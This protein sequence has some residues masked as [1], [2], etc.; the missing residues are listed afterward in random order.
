MEITHANGKLREILKSI[1]ALRW[2]RSSVIQTIDL[3][4]QKHATIRKLKAKSKTIGGAHA[5]HRVIVHS[6]YV[7]RYMR[8][9]HGSTRQDISTGFHTACRR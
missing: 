4:L 7:C 6:T 9:W 1:L 2:E 3:P 5:V 8:T